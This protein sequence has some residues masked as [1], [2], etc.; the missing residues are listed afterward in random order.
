MPNLN[1]LL[2]ALF[3]VPAGA[4]FCVWAEFAL[5]SGGDVGYDKLL[6]MDLER[7]RPRDRLIVTIG[8][9]YMLAFVL[10][11]QLF[12]VGLGNVLLN[13]FIDKRPAVALAVG[14][15]TGLAFP[16][17]KDLIYRLK[18]EIKPKP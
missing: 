1:I 7:W 15:I 14:G 4:A 13:D 6:Y 9:S 11:I 18:P 10:G 12:Q 3:W 8:V 5:R 17:V 16:Y 2:I